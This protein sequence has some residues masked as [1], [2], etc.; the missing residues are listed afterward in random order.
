[1]A[2]LLRTFDD[3]TVTIADEFGT[4]VALEGDRALIGAPLDDTQGG[5]VGQ[6]HL[7]ASTTGTL[8]QTFDDPTVTDDDQFGSFVALSGD[9]VLIGAPGDDTQGSNV[10]QAHLFDTTTGA[11]LQ[12]FADPTV[13]N[14][15]QFGGSVALDGDRALI[16]ARF[17]DTQGN[18]VGQ[19][20]LFDAATGA[21]LQTFD[22]PMVTGGDFFG[23]S[24]ALSGD[25]VLVG[26]P[27]DETQ[28]TNVGQAHLFNATTGALLRTFNDPTVTSLD[29]FGWSVALSGDRVLIGAP[30]DDT[31]GQDVGQAHLF[32]ATTGALLRTFNDP[33]VTGLDQFGTSVALSGDRVLIGAKLD[34]TQGSDVGQAHLFD[35]ITGALLNTLDDPTVTGG[36]NFGFSVALSGDRAL[37]GAF[38][39]DTQGTEVGQA[40]LF[41]IS[42]N[43]PPMAVNDTAATGVGLGV[44]IDVLA[45]DTDPEDD[46]LGIAQA[47]AAA[48][49]APESGTVAVEGEQIRY[50]P[51]PGFAG[52]DIFAYEVSDGAGGTDSALVS[53]RVGQPTPADGVTRGTGQDDAL[54]IAQNATYLGGEGA[55]LFLFSV[56]AREN[57]V[58]LIEGRA[59]DVLQLTEGLE[60]AGYVLAPDALLLDLPNGAQLRVL[61]ADA[62]DFDVGGNVSTGDTG[63]RTDFAGFVQQVLGVGLPNVGENVIGGPLTVAEDLLA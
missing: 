53:V 63:A 5:N 4:S 14:V 51:D 8:L 25:R 19:A 28:G 57:A 32:N 10:G 54:L 27:G 26:A 11:P 40:H 45:N 12:T 50:T 38:R 13:T 37:I 36:D 42:G 3:P 60:I 2:T 31:Q 21:L 59:D 24:V 55:D 7:F 16:G 43:L 22:D 56:A 58:S 39:D 17:D 62:M 23:W 61:Q 34:D 9:R 48:G 15:D 33:T 20:H 35:A 52:I 41:D 44:L 18:N 49:R 29:L 47:G 30:F 46:P 1:M 6:A